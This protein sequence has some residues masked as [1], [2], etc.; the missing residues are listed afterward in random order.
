MAVRMDGAHLGADHAVGAVFQLVDIGRIDRLRK[1]GPTA[2]RFEFVGR[3]E[4]RLAGDDIDI[5]P[6]LLVVQIFAGSRRFGGAL[7]SH[8]ILLGRQ[9][10][11]SLFVLAELRHRY[12]WSIAFSHAKRPE[13]RAQLGDEVLRL[14]PSGVVPAFVEPV[15]VDQ[16]GVGAFRP[17]AWRRVDLIRED[18][19]GDRDGQIFRGEKVEL[20]F[21]V[22]A[23]RGDRGI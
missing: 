20:V 23:R 11:D 10:A 7:L 22:Q 16:L 14:L 21:P 6:G 17:A 13:G 9:L 18:A 19:Y 3:S 2:S 15:V 1:T 4:E 12:S 5:N 8:A